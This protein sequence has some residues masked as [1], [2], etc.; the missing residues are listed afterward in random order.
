[1]R[2]H[3]IFLSFFLQMKIL[4]NQNQVTHSPNSG[5][6]KRI[7]VHEYQEKYEQIINVSQKNQSL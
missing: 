7:Y 3:F 4:Q 1:V 5:H 2:E 6:Q